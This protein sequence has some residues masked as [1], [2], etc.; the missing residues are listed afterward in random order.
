MNE[1]FIMIRKMVQLHLLNH[2]YSKRTNRS[3]VT[4]ISG[5]KARGRISLFK[6]NAQMAD[7]GAQLIGCSVA[8]K[9]AR[10]P[11]AVVQRVVVARNARSAIRQCAPLIDLYAAYERVQTHRFSKTVSFP[12]HEAFHG[13]AYE[14]IRYIT[15]VFAHA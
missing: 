5:R 9:D 1:L 14:V 8:R 3:E 15:L 2:V 6:C 13:R 4:V 7:S 12:E 11:V 10:E